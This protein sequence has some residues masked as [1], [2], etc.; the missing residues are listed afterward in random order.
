MGTARSLSGA[1][2]MMLSGL[3]QFVN[4]SA[5]HAELGQQGNGKRTFPD[6]AI[7]QLKARA[8]FLAHEETGYALTAPGLLSLYR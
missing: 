8:Q 6:T 2:R 3:L 5:S 4:P 7:A 1:G